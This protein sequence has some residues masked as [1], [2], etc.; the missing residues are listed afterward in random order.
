MLFI[1]FAYEN[2]KTFLI[3]RLSVLMF[4]FT[5]N[6]YCIGWL[7]GIGLILVH[8]VWWSIKQLDFFPINVIFFLKIFKKYF[9][10]LFTT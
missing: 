2:L 7:N 1:T 9:I 10:I 6:F 8:M 4:E 3:W 5:T